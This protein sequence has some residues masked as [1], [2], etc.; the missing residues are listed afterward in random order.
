MVFKV[1]A[2]TEDNIQNMWSS[3]KSAHQTRKNY[4]NVGSLDKAPYKSRKI[5]RWETLDLKEVRKIKSAYEPSGPPGRSLS[6]F[7]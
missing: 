2:G 6:R 4:V 7:P 5:A 1:V 3:D